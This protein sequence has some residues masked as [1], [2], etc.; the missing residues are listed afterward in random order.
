MESSILTG[1]SA[2]IYGS[3]GWGSSPSE[4]TQLTGPLP[5]RQRAFL[6]LWEPRTHVSRRTGA[7]SRLS[8][9]PLVAFEQVPVHVFGDGDAGMP[10]CFSAVREPRFTWDRWRGFNASRVHGRLG[11]AAGAGCTLAAPAS[12]KRR[13]SGWCPMA[14]FR[15][16]AEVLRPD[17]PLMKIHQAATMWRPSRYR[18]AEIEQALRTEPGV[19]LGD[20]LRRT[21]GAYEGPS[22]A[23]SWF[24]DRRS[25][26]SSVSRLGARAFR[27]RDRPR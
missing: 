9:R 16:Y 3:E 11:V 15:T 23:C 14:T 2:L 5:A 18:S 22:H 26:S 1:R 21:G 17:H 25:R 19:V 8:R 12:H 20:V 24:A 27:A 7:G 6:S 13:Q 4:C 10:E